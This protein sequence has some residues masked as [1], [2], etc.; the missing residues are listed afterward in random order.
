MIQINFRNYE[1]VN[2]FKFTPMGEA[3]LLVHAMTKARKLYKAG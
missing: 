2:R 1:Y 3:N